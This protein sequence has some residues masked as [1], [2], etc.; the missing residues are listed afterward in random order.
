MRHGGI[1]GK[2]REDLAASQPLSAITTLA[3]RVDRMNLE[4]TLF[5]RSRPIVVISPMD[6]SLCW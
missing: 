3:H 4:D 2:E 6:G 5:A 1:F